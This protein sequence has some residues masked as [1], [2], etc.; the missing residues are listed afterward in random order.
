MPIG[1]PATAI[2]VPPSVWWLD[3][4][5]PDRYAGLASAEAERRARLVGPDVG[6]AQH[7]P[8]VLCQVAVRLGNPLVLILL[9]AGAISATTGDLANFAIIVAMVL[10]SVALDFVQE[11]RAGHAAARA[12]VVLRARVVRDGTASDV[13]VD[14]LV[15]GD[16]VQLCAGDRVP[17]DARVIEARDFFVKQ[18]LLTGELYP[19]EKSASLPT[20]GATELAQATNADCSFI[21]ASWNQHRGAV[22]PARAHIGQGFVRLF[23]RI[24]RGL[25]A[26]WMEGNEAEEV[27]GV[28][29]RQIG[30]RHQVTLAPEQ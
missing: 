20:S 1:R 17:A 27:A 15:P 6:G 21:A 28:A 24:A 4:A 26:Q 14:R 7:A 2:A 29:S 11:R 30:H 9:V 22:Q 25:D 3:S 5:A 18:G 19:V 16:Q 8:S 13:A 23:Q 10:L 12:S